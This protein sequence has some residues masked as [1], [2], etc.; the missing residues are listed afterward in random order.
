[1]TKTDDETSSE[2]QP[3]EP[4]T[5]V[6]PLTSI[7]T[8]VGTHIMQALGQAETV[9]VITMVTGSSTGQ[10]I[11]SMPLDADD[12]NQVQTLLAQVD[13][14]DEPHTEKC[15]GFHCDYPLTNQEED[16]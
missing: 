12:M 9:A 3:Q 1:M 7:Q 14:N 10:Q 11:V 13:A 8:Q 5:L 15:V 2:S 16:T 6:T 4:Q